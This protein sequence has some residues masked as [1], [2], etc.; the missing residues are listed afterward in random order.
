MQHRVSSVLVVALIRT[1]CWLPSRKVGKMRKHR[2]DQ[3]SECC[4]N[5]KI[6]L[7]FRVTITHENVVDAHSFGAV[8]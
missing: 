7:L 2:S 4:A 5:G 3:E 1:P 6:K 8:Q